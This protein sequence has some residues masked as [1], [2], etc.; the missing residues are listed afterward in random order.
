MP[1]TNI[2]LK[3]FNHFAEFCTELLVKTAVFSPL[4]TFFISALNNFCHH[5]VRKLCYVSE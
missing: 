4:F 3:F 2:N 1:I 5:D